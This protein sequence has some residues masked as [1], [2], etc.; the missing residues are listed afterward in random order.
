MASE[1]WEG[2][3]EMIREQRW[4][5]RDRNTEKITRF[6]EIN[7]DVIFMNIIQPHQIRLTGL[8]GKRIDIYPITKKYH[9]LTNKKRGQM[10]NIKTF[11]AGYF[12][13]LT[14]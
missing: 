14:D 8:N 10:K 4:D 12:E 3:N 2:F 13:L 1:D 6:I 5:K 9:D 7:K 11:L